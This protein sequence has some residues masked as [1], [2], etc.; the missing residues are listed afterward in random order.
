M[1]IQ[2]SDKA[3]R[4]GGRPFKRIGY[5]WAHYM[6]IYFHLENV[7]QIKSVQK[8]SSVIEHGLQTLFE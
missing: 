8:Y 2:F 1:F 5:E 3:G 7:I 4:K 6:K